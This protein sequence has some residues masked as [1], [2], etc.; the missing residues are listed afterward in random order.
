MKWEMRAGA[1][2]RTGVL[3]TT[4]AIS[5]AYNGKGRKARP[6][7]TKKTRVVPSA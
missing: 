7:L 3:G 1:H 5:T 2:S 6:G 4:E